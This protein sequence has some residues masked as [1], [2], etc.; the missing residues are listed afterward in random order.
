MHIPD[1]LLNEHFDDRYFDVVDAVYEAKQIHIGNARVVER[2][3]DSV[4]DKKIFRIGETGFGAGRLLIALMASL[5]EGGVRGA[6]IDYCTVEMYPVPAERMGRI[7][8]VLGDGAGV[9]ARRLLD[10]YSRVDTS[11]PGPHTVVIPGDYGVVNLR[12]RVGEALE[13]VEALDAPRGAWFLDG[14][15]PKKNPGIWRA[16]LMAAV[17]RKTEAG[18]TAT[19]FTVAGHVRRA[20]SVAGFAVE[21][22]AGCGGKKEALLAVMGGKRGEN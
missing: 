20:L 13:M 7:L 3:L 17:G 1:I 5:D 12:L 22:T 10:A 18:G 8:G 9:Y 14:H 11:S 15:S 6:E 21:K 16:E 19:A 2:V 4:A